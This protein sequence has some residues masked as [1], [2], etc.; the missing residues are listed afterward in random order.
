VRF[1]SVNVN[2]TIFLMSHS[3]VHLGGYMWAPLIKNRFCLAISLSSFLL[4]CGFLEIQLG[5][6][7]GLSASVWLIKSNVHLHLYLY[8][9]SIIIWNLH[10]SIFARSNSTPAIRQG[11][12]EGCLDLD[13]STNGWAFDTVWH[14]CQKCDKIIKL[15]RPL[16]LF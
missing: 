7:N 1:H 14:V 6:S 12:H 16:Q 13:Y 8:S 11:D 15:F 10:Q 3:L 9:M 2:S 5:K 4:N